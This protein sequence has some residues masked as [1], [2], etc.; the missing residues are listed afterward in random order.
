MS[1]ADVALKYTHK[2]LIIKCCIESPTLK[3]TQQKIKNPSTNDWNKNLKHLLS[4][5]PKKFKFLA[6]MR[7]TDW[8]IQ[9]NGNHIDKNNAEQLRDA[10]QQLPPV[11]IIEIHKTI[12][13]THKQAHADDIGYIITVHF[14]DKQYDFNLSANSDVWDESLYHN[15]QNKIKNIFNLSPEFELYEDIDGDHVNMD[16]MNDI[17]GAFEDEDSSA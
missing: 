7:E 10:L 8:K 1:A 4:K 11:P 13:S 15:L 16:D 5:I 14:R 9:I 17:L 6:N 2:V 12:D 3:K